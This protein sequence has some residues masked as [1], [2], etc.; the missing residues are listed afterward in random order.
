MRGSVSQSCL[1]LGPGQTQV[2]RGKGGLSRARERAG[3]SQHS[4]A[5]SELGLSLAGAGVLGGC[6]PRQVQAWSSV[7]FATSHVKQS[8]AP[9]T[10]TQGLFRLQILSREVGKAQRGLS[11][12][13]SVEGQ[14]LWALDECVCVGGGNSL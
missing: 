14:D 7:G 1:G 11:F 3:H 2:F 4:D 5:P 12:S 9:R 6:G 10:G 8:I 13:F